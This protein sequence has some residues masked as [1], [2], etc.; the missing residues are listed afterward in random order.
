MARMVWVALGAAGGIYA[1]RKSSRALAEARERGLVGNVNAATTSATTAAGNVRSLIAY[2]RRR[3]AE[4]AGGHAHEV[5]A[6]NLSAWN[7]PK[8]DDAS[9]TSLRSGGTPSSPAPR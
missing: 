1:Y 4:R 7:Q 2:S 3:A 9:S 5:T 8:S 6:G